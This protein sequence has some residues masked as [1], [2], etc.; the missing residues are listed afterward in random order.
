MLTKGEI[1]QELLSGCRIFHFGT[2]S[3]TDEPCRTAT[4]SAVTTAK[5]SG[6][7]VSFDPNLRPPLW[8]DDETARQMIRLGLSQSDIVKISDD[9]VK[10]VTGE[11]DSTRGAETL[12][13]EF[14]EIKLLCVT[15]GP[16]GSFAY[17]HGM[18]VFEPAYLLGNTVDTTGAG[19][20]F[21]ACVL[22][23]VLDHGLLDLDEKSLRDML[24]FA[25][26]A[27]Y[28]VTTKKGVIKSVPDADEVYSIVRRK[29]R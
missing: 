10:F 18:R 15:S 26:A 14:R 11:N 12:L 8:K 25:N 6:A 22:N 5:S 19:D 27:A 9:E 2:L 4:Q 21:C 3:M 24:Q 13:E 23:Y 17:Y 29:N 28:L 1:S 16:S 7:T 20:I